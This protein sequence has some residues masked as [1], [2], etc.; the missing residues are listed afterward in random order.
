MK[1]EAEKGWFKN[2][3]KEVSVRERREEIN[4]MRLL[5]TIG[6]NTDKRPMDSDRQL[7]LKENH[8]LESEINWKQ[9]IRLYNNM[10]NERNG[11]KVQIQTIQS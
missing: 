1:G 6:V 9:N 8:P 7:N 11:K 4:K 2:R 10:W 5:R 3:E